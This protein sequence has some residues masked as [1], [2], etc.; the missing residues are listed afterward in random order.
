MRV[1]ILFVHA[2][3]VYCLSVAYLWGNGGCWLGFAH[4]ETT[5]MVVI[6][7]RTGRTTDKYD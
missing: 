6:K 1:M 7:C 4:Y 2:W 5:F 3:F